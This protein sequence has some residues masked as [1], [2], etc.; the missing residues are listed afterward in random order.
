M[1]E[2]MEGGRIGAIFHWR[3]GTG[4]GGRR[5]GGKGRGGGMI[6]KGGVK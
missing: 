1:D 2:W 6:V 4:N 3:G 5:K